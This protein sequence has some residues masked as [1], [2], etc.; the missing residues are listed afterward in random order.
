MKVGSYLLFDMLEGLREIDS[1]AVAE[2]V[3]TIRVCREHGSRVWIVGN[4]GSA[5]TASHFANDLIKMARVDA[6]CIPDMGPTVLAYGNDDGWENMFS[7]VIKRLGKENDALVAISCSGRSANIVQCARV[8][9]HLGMQIIVLTGRNGNL[10]ENPLA[11]FV[12]NPICVEFD[13][14]K[15]QEDCHLAICHAIAGVLAKDV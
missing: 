11:G 2:A 15:V 13:D 12:M 7:S 5:A 4:G 1:S 8:A 9:S 10:D 6:T 3:E 14:I